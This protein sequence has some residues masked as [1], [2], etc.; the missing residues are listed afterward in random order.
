M[1]AEAEA[2]PGEILTSHQ[3]LADDDMYRADS[4]WRDAHRGS[5]WEP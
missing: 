3:H 1:T 2:G 4:R 5:S